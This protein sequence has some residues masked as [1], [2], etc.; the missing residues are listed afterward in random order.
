MPSTALLAPGTLVYTVPNLAR[1]VPL[2]LLSQAGADAAEAARLE[3]NEC[4]ITSR[5]MAVRMKSPI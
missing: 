3:L 1:S 5:Q 4:E 2:E